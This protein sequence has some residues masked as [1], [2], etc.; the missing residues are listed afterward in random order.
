MPSARKGCQKVS[1][2]FTRKK[3]KRQLFFCKF[4]IF[5]EGGYSTPFLNLVLI[6]LVLI[7]FARLKNRASEK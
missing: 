3:K 6:L 2:P 1:D 5:V 7:L 4:F